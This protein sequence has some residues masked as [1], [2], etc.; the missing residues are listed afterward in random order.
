MNELKSNHSSSHNPL[1]IRDYLS[2]DNTGGPGFNF[3][4]HI[5]RLLNMCFQEWNWVI[6]K[7]KM[8][9]EVRAETTRLSHF[10]QREVLQ[11]LKMWSC[12]KELSFPYTSVSTYR[13]MR[14]SMFKLILSEEINLKGN[15]I[16]N[17]LYW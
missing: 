6:F 17:K 7:K 9:L 11:T 13:R 12:L 16:L 1:K 3:I 2:T 5:G 8:N 14:C 15:Y 4:I 10:L